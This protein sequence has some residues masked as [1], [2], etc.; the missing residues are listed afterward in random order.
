MLFFGQYW[1]PVCTEHVDTPV[2]EECLY[3]DEIIV[4]DDQ[5]TITTCITEDSDNP[6]KLINEVRPIHKECSFRDVMGG[7]GHQQDHVY[8]CK[9]MRD[10]DGGKSKRE[11]AILVWNHFRKLDTGKH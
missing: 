1:A 8:W 10:P 4:E 3:C 5:G 2:G 9:K 6:G 11:S 7:W